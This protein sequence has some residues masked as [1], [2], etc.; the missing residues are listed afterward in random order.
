MTKET[1]IIKVSSYA[2]KSKFDKKMVVAPMPVAQ[3]KAMVQ[4]PGEE[5]LEI[6]FGPSQG[7]KKLFPLKGNKMTMDIE[8]KSPSKALAA[9]T[10]KTSYNMMVAR[11]VQ[12][13]MEDKK[14]QG[15]DQK[16]NYQNQQEVLK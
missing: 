7:P 5:E 11:S 1:S 10:K 14:T 3:G 15:K 2:S 13:R 8:I 16:N 12:E 4:A 9:P 6:D